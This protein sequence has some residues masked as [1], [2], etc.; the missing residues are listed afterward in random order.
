MKVCPG[1]DCE[2]TVIYGRASGKGYERIPN[3]MK[4][5]RCIEVQ[6]S[7]CLFGV[8]PIH[9]NVPQVPVKFEPE[10]NVSVIR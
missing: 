1:H 8:H 2:L 10:H 9:D 7:V 3:V 6:C 5:D 4:C